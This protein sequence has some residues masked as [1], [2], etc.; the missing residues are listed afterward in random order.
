VAKKGFGDLKVVHGNQRGFFLNSRGVVEFFRLIYL[1][2]RVLLCWALDES[3]DVDCW[4]A[5]D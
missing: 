3:E 1:G 4:L 2:G 5:V